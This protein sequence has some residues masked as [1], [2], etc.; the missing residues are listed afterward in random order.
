MN[1]MEKKQTRSEWF[2]SSL[3]AHIATFQVALAVPYAVVFFVLGL[4]D[5]T[6]T[7][8]R[9]FCIL[10]GSMLVSLITAI[11]VWYLITV[12]VVQKYNLKD[13]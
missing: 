12:R 7:V 2:R 1:S 11:L 6:L 9:V 3:S 13:H 8:A 10:F 4:I 5:G